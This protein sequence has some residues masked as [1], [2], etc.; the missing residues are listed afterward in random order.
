MFKLVGALLALYT[1]YAAISGQVFAKSG[2][3]GR[4][5]LKAESPGYFWVVI[6]IYAT[7]SVALITVF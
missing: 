2:I 4:T 5:V 1:T 6:V 3:S 7:L